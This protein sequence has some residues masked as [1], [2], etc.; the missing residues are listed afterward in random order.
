MA[1]E[2]RLNRQ[3]SGAPA[4]MLAAQMRALLTPRRAVA[5][6]CDTAAIHMSNYPCIDYIRAAVARRG[7]S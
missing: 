2:Y 3:F 6:A 4:C 5:R 1:V 7:L